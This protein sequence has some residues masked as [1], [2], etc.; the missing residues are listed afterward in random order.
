MHLPKR[1]GYLQRR[2]R[3]RRGNKS[4][5]PCGC[6]LWDLAPITP[7]PTARWRATLEAWQSPT[8]SD[9]DT[10]SNWGIPVTDDLDSQVRQALQRRRRFPRI[11]LYV[12]ML[13]AFVGTSGY[14]WLHYDSLAKLAFAG[15]SAGAPDLHST[16]TGLT[17]K[18]FEA[19]RQQTAESLQ[20]VIED[21]DAQ[22]AD[23]ERL[24]DQVLTLAAKI[25]ARQST[26]TSTDSL[27]APTEVRP[28]SPQPTHARTAVIA[29][30]RKKPR[31]PKTTG[32]ISVGG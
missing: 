6:G 9:R 4:I 29:A 13:S 20:S 32:P 2:I 16:D 28:G 12:C 19:F 24:S 30:A 5:G 31:A 17:Q 8:T 26:A 3:R 22:K 18:D 10:K 23:L 25:D 14:L 1:V 7:V 11:I 15:R 21:I 27:S